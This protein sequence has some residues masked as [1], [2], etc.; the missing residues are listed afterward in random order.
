MAIAA[1]IAAVGIVYREASGAYFFEDDFQW[2][3]GTL[4]YDPASLLDFAGRT[5]FYRPIIELYFWLGTPLFRGSPELFHVAN[6]VLHAFNGSLL[7]V[8]ASRVARSD[9]FGFVAA[10]TFVVMPGYVE[11]VTWVGALAEPVGA[12]FGLLSI[13]SF[14]SYR[15]GG[16]IGPLIVSLVTFLLALLTHESSLV[17]LPV[18]VLTDWAADDRVTLIPRSP[19]AWMTAIRTYAPYVVVVGLYL[20]PDLSV[21]QRSYLVEEGHYR[22]GFHA[23]PNILAYIVS[24][25]VGKR[26]LASFIT[27][28]VALALIVVFGSRR[29]RLAVCW[30]ILALMPFVFFTW[31]NTSRYLY[32]PAMGFGMLLAEGVLWL[33][34]V[35]ARRLAPTPRMAVIAL[36]IAALTIRFAVFAS[37]GVTNFSKRTSV[38]RHFAQMLHQTTPALAPNSVVFISAREEALMKHRYLEGLVRWEYRDPTL[39]VAVRRQ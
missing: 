12:C 13:I 24:L 21:N 31:G 29:A 2:L 39:Q 17:F 32:L 10:V 4:T 22:V 25:Y 18:L 11:A 7:F 35:L 38:Y 30:M 5:H 1:V 14:L 23:I 26:N 9:L 34:G 3:A 19:G 28:V 36:L 8:L 37:E 20:I 27:I 33:N 15:R 16:R 6:V